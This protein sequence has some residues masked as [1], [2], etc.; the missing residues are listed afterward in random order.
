MGRIH[1]SGLLIPS[2]N[3]WTN[4]SGR[5][6]MH[7]L[8]AVYGQPDS[9]RAEQAEAEKAPLHHGGMAERTRPAAKGR[10]ADF[11]NGGQGAEEAAGASAKRVRAA[12]GKNAGRHMAHRSMSSLILSHPLLKLVSHLLYVCYYNTIRSNFCKRVF[13]IAHGNSKHD[14]HISRRGKIAFFNIIEKCERTKSRFFI[15]DLTVYIYKM[16]TRRWRNDQTDI[17][18]VNF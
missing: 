2:C 6:A 16:C 4:L 9:H 17:I 7:P 5:R 8:C 10:L 14:L 18:L 11:Q 15:K 12:K 13:I 1:H 3:L